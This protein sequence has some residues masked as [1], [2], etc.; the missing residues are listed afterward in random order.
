MGIEIN[1]L[2][3]KAQRLADVLI[4]DGEMQPRLLKA[5]DANDETKRG[6]NYVCG[7]LENALTEEQISE[8][9]VPDSD[10]SAGNN[11]PDK[12]AK[13]GDTPAGSVLRTMFNQM[14]PQDKKRVDAL[15]RA[16]N[17]KPSADD[18]PF[19]D[20]DGR[21]LGQPTLVAMLEQA[22]G[23]YNNGV[24]TFKDGV[25][26]LQMFKR[27]NEMAPE[28]VQ[29]KWGKDRY[30]L[31]VPLVLSDPTDSLR[32]K[33][34]SVNTFI[35]LD[36]DEAEKNLA[37]DDKSK[38]FDALLGTIKRSAS[39]GEKK[40]K[41][42]KITNF[43][44]LE[45]SG[46]E[47]VTFLAGVHDADEQYARFLKLLATKKAHSLIEMIGDVYTSY[48]DLYAVPIV[49]EVYAEILKKRADTARKERAEAEAV[50]EQN[51]KEG[52]A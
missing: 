3:A 8:L 18:E 52:R 14:F 44:D 11:N 7:V 31:T 26:L 49:K 27:V 32:T 34:M 9:P 36:I 30:H 12:W 1:N 10:E 24:V 21:A 50:I 2:L 22:R 16:A 23:R 45:V 43:D 25:W 46:T 42:F 6:A 33:P 28:Y 5:M 29:V 38:A 35:K 17:N 41:Q 51:K 37:P 13:N 20:D 4:E 39:V 15:A 47:H 40:A 48:G 19:V